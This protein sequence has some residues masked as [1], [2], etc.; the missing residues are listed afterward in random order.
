MQ[1]W[2]HIDIYKNHKKGCSMVRNWMIVSVL[3]GMLFV[4]EKIVSITA[5]QVG[6]KQFV[7]RLAT[8]IERTL[9]AAQKRTLSSAEKSKVADAISELERRAPKRADEIREKIQSSETLQTQLVGVPKMGITKSEPLTAPIQTTSKAPIISEP[10]IAP[11]QMIEAP[12]I[13]VPSVDVPVAGKESEEITASL[14]AIQAKV[15]D[16]DNKSIE[17][18]INGYFNVTKQIDDW[19][20]FARRNQTLTRSL[21]EQLSREKER[22]YRRLAKLLMDDLKTKVHEFVRLMKGKDTFPYYQIVKIQQAIRDKTPD[23]LESKELYGDA[24]TKKELDTK[25]VQL[26]T[27]LKSARID[28]AIEKPDI[29][30]LLVDKDGNPRPEY[31]ESINAIRLFLFGRLDPRN[32]LN[33]TSLASLLWSIAYYINQVTV[34]IQKDKKKAMEQ[35]KLY[36]ED[37]FD[38]LMQFRNML[39][40]IIPPK[41]VE[42]EIT[43]II[44]MLEPAL[45]RETKLRFAKKKYILQPETGTISDW[46]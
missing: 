1:K 8:D 36:V 26:F 42:A 32:Q 31:Q 25:Y 22:I 27:L 21:L 33:Q 7:E 17:E 19:W 11:V 29:N 43:D 28:E 18:R 30:I 23:F 6:E 38:L 44:N 9:D 4:H 24:D 16:L 39:Q 46:D 13:E 37:N 14:K 45:D 20:N 40:S 12:L 15:A 34:K 5:V 41:S 35:V 10:L 3:I 2:W